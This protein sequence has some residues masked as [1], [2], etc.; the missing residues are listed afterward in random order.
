[1]TTFSLSPQPALIGTLEIAL[2]LGLSRAYITDF[3]TKQVWFP[4]PK[5]NFSQKSRRW[6]NTEVLAAVAQPR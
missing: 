5:I 6:L 1:M 4:K 2:M 3:L